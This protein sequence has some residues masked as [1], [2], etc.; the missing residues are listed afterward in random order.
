VRSALVA[1]T[2]TCAIA[3]A[4]QP[5]PLA[6]PQKLIAAANFPAA[7]AALRAYLVTTPASAPAHYLL[8]YSLLRQNKPQD[9]LQEYTRAAA[10]TPPN[11]E[12]LRSVG[13]AYVLLDDLLD[14]GKWMTRAVEMNR[15]DPE[16]WY[17][18]G[19]LR[20]TEQRYTDA[21][22]C[23]TRAL[24]LAPKSVKVENNLGLAYEGLNRPDDAVAAYRQAI[25]WQ[26]A[27]PTA[28]PSEQP[29]LNLAIALI[30]R[31]EVAE[32]KPLLLHAIAIAPADP[33]IQEQLGQI[34]LQQGDFSDAEKYLKTAVHLDPDKSNLHFLLGQ[35][36][37]HLGHQQEAKA[38]FDAAARLA[39]APVNPQN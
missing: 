18:L 15:S 2:L 12:E 28:P 7:E 9:A 26:D 32:A 13:Q 25:A 4:Q 10:L 21:L 8:A 36:Y 19:R 14:A 30:H 35:A 24:A 6:S 29:L 1:L 38:E 39:H 37:R 33:R 5:S 20:Y 23:F 16:S 34:C 11:A 3:T 17:S 27:A 31:G 22:D